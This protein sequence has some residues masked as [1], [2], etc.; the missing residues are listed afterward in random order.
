MR[1]LGK[2]DISP[3]VDFIYHGEVKIPEN[4]INSF[5]SLAEELQLKGLAG[6][7]EI[8]KKKTK[9]YFDGKTTTST[10][11][12]NTHMNT[13]HNKTNSSTPDI[14]LKSVETNKEEFTT[15]DITE[16]IVADYPEH[17]RPI[18]NISDNIDLNQKMTELI[19]WDGETWSCTVCDKKATSTS[20]G[21]ANLKRH[22]Q[23]HM[24]GVTYPC[25]PCGK[26]FRT[27][28]CVQVHSY[29]K[30]KTMV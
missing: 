20:M 6:G 15:Y 25:I 4:E 5:L 18:I 11:Q 23:T 29:K 3:I 21:K 2:S 13:K 9:E 12:N 22:T 10:T 8:Y 24:Q 26:E 16:S 7:A 14:V 27:K 30:H 28:N 1:G 17:Y 19:E